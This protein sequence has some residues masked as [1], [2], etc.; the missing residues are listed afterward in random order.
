[1]FVS[2]EGRETMPSVLLTGEA[3]QGALAQQLAQFLANG[4]SAGS[5]YAIVGVG[6]GISYSVCKYFQFTQAAL[7]ALGAYMA[8]SCFHL[9]GLPMILAIA[10]AT[11]GWLP[12][13]MRPAPVCI[14]GYFSI[15]SCTL[16]TRAILPC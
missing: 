14:H 15:L 4:I 1:M 11:L 6:F 9:A 12:S 10:V 16:R 8:W 3:L 5:V 7:I 13:Y 2:L